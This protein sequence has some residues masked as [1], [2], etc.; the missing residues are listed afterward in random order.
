MLVL[1]RDAGQAE[2]AA[3]AIRDGGGAAAAL[4][5]DVTDR[6]GVAG[7]I[8]DIFTE[9]THVDKLVTCAGITCPAPL[10]SLDAAAWHRV[11]DVNLNGT[12]HVLQAVAAENLRRG[13][14]CAAVTVASVAAFRGEAG[15]GSYCVSKAGVIALTRLAAAEWSS[16]GIRVNAVAPGYVDTPMLGAATSAGLIDGDA[17]MNR[18]PA[19]R[20]A[21]PDEI[22]SAVSFLLSASSSYMCGSVL[23][24]DGGFLIDHGVPLLGAPNV[25]EA[26]P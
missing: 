2:M 7:L 19:R 25:Q 22:A 20:A 21:H 9:Y 6:E 26:Q 8:A 10:E 5:C 4:A 15:R 17:L 11:L 24:V 16:R 3:Q 1:D 18:I 12:F 14:R 23:T 13:H